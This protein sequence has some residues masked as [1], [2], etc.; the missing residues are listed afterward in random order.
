VFLDGEA[1]HRHLAIKRRT[2]PDSILNAG[3]LIVA[4]QEC[5][6]SS[7]CLDTYVRMNVHTVHCYPDR[8]FI[9]YNL[10]LVF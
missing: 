1:V 8:V 10:E 6:Q 4:S 9:I 7:D 5:H 3:Q 2:I